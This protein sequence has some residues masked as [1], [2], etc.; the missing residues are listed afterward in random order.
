[1]DNARYILC[2]VERV[3]IKVGRYKSLALVG[4]GLARVTLNND[5][6]GGESGAFV[7]CDRVGRVNKIDVLDAGIS[8][9]PGVVAVAGDAGEVVVVK[10]SVEE[11]I[12][13]GVALV[14]TVEPV[15]VDSALD[16]DVVGPA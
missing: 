1:M 3:L 5:T 15:V 12:G 14:R 16:D 9:A 7:G 11:V 2:C 4:R 10:V 8:A 6:C 13:R